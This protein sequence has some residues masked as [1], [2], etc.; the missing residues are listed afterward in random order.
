[1]N[2]EKNEEYVFENRYS[3]LTSS[4]IIFG[5]K[6]L[7]NVVSDHLKLG[8]LKVCHVCYSCRFAVVINDIK[9]QTAGVRFVIRWHAYFVFLKSPKWS[10]QL[11]YCLVSSFN[12][13]T[14]PQH[15]QM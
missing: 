10:L 13:A 5:C 9:V 3:S 11:I 14:E 15:L 6:E 12:E 7:L 1:M 8:N 2:S 4:N